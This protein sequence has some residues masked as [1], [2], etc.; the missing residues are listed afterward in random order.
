MSPKLLKPMNLF[1]FGKLWHCEKNTNLFV[2]VFT[3]ACSQQSASKLI[4]PTAAGVLGMGL[5]SVLRR[6]TDLLFQPQ[7]HVSSEY[8]HTSLSGL[9]RDN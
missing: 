6:D 4:L 8:M 5:C 9:K 3:K 7:N 1:L 2:H